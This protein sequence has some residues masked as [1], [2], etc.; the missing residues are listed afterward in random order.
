MREKL[1]N[2]GDDE[3]HV[4]VATFERFGTK[5]GYK[6]EEKTVLL[7]DVRLV[8]TNEILTDHLWF[9]ATK[10]FLN[11]KPK[12]GDKIQ[13]QGRVEW[14]EKGYFGRRED[15]YVPESTDYKI[16]RPSKVK[17]L[18]KGIESCIVK[19]TKEEIE[20]E[21]IVKEEQRK[22]LEEERKEREK[23]WNMATES[24]LE[25]IAIIAKALEIDMPEITQ[26]KEASK[27]INCYLPDYQAQLKRQKGVEHRKELIKKIIPLKEQG[28][29]T[30][31][32][33]EKVQICAATYYRCMKEYNNAK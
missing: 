19:R 6:G 23:V 7:S 18:T 29:S 24:Q 5:H 22:Q 27:W 4:F 26:K 10:G 25:F 16:S 1:K 9:N 21:R 12:K 2:L 30:K 33:C 3:R 20:A 31:E 32:I 13:F 28:L 14:Y 15:V 17:N 11:V 8:E